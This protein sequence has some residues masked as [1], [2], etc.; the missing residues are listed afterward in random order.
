[1]PFEVRRSFLVVGAF[2]LVYVTSWI[3]ITSLLNSAVPYDALEALNWAY[4]GEFGSPKNPY[5]VGWVMSLGLLMEPIVPIS[6]YWYASHFIGVGT[7]MLG[8]WLLGKRLFGDNQVAILSLL[9]L[10]ASGIINF[11]IIPYNDNYLLVTMWPYVF[12]F[13]IK[14]VYDNSYYW[15]PLALV[16]GLA[17]MSKYSSCVFLPSMF[18]CTLLVPR[19]RKA[20]QSATIYLAILLLPLIALP[21]VVWLS[22]HDFAAFN[23]VESQLTIG[24][25]TSLPV[26]FLA[27][28]Y[29]VV[30]LAMILRRLGARW[31]SPDTPEKRLILQVFLPPLVFVLGYL[32][33]HR[34]GNMT[35]WLQ[36]FVVLGSVVL[37][38]VTDF[39]QI[40]SLQSMLRFYTGL[41]FIVLMGYALVLIMNLGGAS[42]K[43]NFVKKTSVDINAIWRERYDRPLKYVGGSRF[44]HWLTF[45]A[46]DRPR[47]VTPW[48][49]ERKPNIYNAS[50]TG[51]DVRRDGALLISD[52]GA[53]FDEDTLAL[54]L[55]TVPGT[56][57][58]EHQEF[59]FQNERG[60]TVTV[61]LGFL[62]PQESF[63]LDQ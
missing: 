30:L 13:F 49:N 50:I 24:L 53:P 37:F 20:Y 35:E 28:F 27:V 56:K 34:G 43:N 39:K 7:G 46:P 17:A 41:S 4:T 22:K 5:F 61:I 3:V 51:D 45:Y 9:S 18:A 48:S 59:S 32:L 21:N 52:P 1:M 26:I 33:V 12:L 8:V 38:C 54:D 6:V 40:Q 44:S 57:V 19:A 31:S 36:P 58:S 25:N 60:K 16:C 47:V 10:N 55:S 63:N 23:W 29:P 15:Y 14:A 2:I 11:D 42:A 62:P